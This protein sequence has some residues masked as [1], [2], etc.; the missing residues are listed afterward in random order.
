MDSS[1]VLF[2][3]LIK[4]RV[5]RAKNGSIMVGPF[6]LMKRALKLY[7]RGASLVRYHGQPAH[8]VR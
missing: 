5:C 7:G 2:C 3:V 8:E 1:K 4:N 6:A